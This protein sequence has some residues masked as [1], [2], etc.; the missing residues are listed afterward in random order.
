MTATTLDTTHQQENVFW[1][2]SQALYQ[3]TDVEKICLAYQ[4]KLACNVNLLLFCCWAGVQGRQFSAEEI[5]SAADLIRNWDSQVV[6]QLRQLRQLV[7]SV[8]ETDAHAF[9]EQMGELEIIAEQIVQNSLYQWWDELPDYQRVESQVAVVENIN[10]YLAQ[11]DSEF[12]TKDNP[13]VVAALTVR[14]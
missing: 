1:V 8:D 2:Y 14:L 7:K 13:L 11:F 9:R 3:T 6:Q 4:Q 5:A 10:S 12:V